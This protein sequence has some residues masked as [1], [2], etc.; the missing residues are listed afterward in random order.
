MTSRSVFGKET[1]KEWKII[2]V[3]TL[4]AFAS[5][6]HLGKISC[7]DV[8]QDG[9]L[10]EGHLLSRRSEEAGSGTSF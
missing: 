9:Q 10:F 8:K 5:I 1:L 2:S 7:A 3:G 6:L 4:R